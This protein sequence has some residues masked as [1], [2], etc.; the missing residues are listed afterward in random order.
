MKKKQN[1]E[2]KNSILV[3]GQAVMEGVMMRTPKAYATAVRNPQGA[4]VTERKPF[5]SLAKK[6]KIYGWPVIRGFVSMI[7]SLKIGM[8]T[9]NFSADIAYP[10]EAAKEKKLGS[11]ITS[12]L[13]T[14]FAFVLALVLFMIAPMWI[15]EKLFGLRDSAAL[16][17]ISA[18]F[19]RILFFLLYLVIIS[20]LKD[21]R[22]LFAYH[23][24]E[25]KTIYAFE[26]GEELTTENIKKYSRFHPRC[27]TSFLFITMINIIILYAVLD[28]LV[29]HIFQT[30]L[31]IQLRLLYH[32]PFIPVVMGVGY[33]VLK[34]SSRNLDKWY[35]AWMSKPG[36]WLQRITTRKPEDGMI[37]C[38]VAALKTG[39]G[40][41]WDLYRGGTFVAEAIE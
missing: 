9:L 34:F 17:N 6:K 39:F 20:M 10:E 26:S 28:A 36:L 4:I 23:G 13:S 11:K 2:T 14:L 41:E 12:W 15:T 7:E 37:E 3:G 22:R 32:L 21:V 30:Q 35:V 24:A 8:E 27:G 40:D 38:A 1:K 19:F 31:T 29:M 25:H 18:G 5:T 16:F 33:E